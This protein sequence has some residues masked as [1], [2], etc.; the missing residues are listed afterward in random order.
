MWT[1]P[2]PPPRRG[3][4]NYRCGTVTTDFVCLAALVAEKHSTS[5][6]NGFKATRFISPMDLHCGQ[7]SSGAAC[8]GSA[9]CHRGLGLESS[10]WPTRMAPGLGGPEELAV[11]AGGSSWASLSVASLWSLQLYKVTV[12][13]NV[14]CQE[15]EGVHTGQMPSWLLIL[16]LKPCSITPTCSFS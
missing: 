7:G 3:G 16:P 13:S 15:Q 2:P 11:G 4:E 12:G 9:H 5:K 14:T 6:L 1:E 8:F 10:L